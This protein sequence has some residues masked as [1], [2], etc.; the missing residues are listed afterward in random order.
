MQRSK[1]PEGKV[2]NPENRQRVL[3]EGERPDSGWKRG[4]QRRSILI[5]PEPSP[6]EVENL[7]R[8]FLEVVEL[9]EDEVRV[10]TEEWMA[11]TVVARGLGRRV[12]AEATIREFR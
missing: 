2:G 6:E 1:A 9:P 8:R 5:S 7:V 3:R 12:A 11:T 10:E 4:L